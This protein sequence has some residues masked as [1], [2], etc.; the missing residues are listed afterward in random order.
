MDLAPL[1]EPLALA[2]TVLPNRVMTSAMTMQYGEDGLISDRH[3]AL[4]E[5]RARGGVGLMFSEQLTASPLS[6]SPFGDAIDAYD[7]RQVARFAALAERLAPYDSRFFAQLFCGGVVG[8]STG[9]L[10]GWAPV[11][12]PSRVGMPGGEAAL[13][14]GGRRSRGSPPT[15]PA[16]PAT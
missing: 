1:F 8:S 15:S 5:E 14:L 2:G 10:A 12:G 16:P 6:G 7:E 11:R 13:P 3:L 4:Y 9:G